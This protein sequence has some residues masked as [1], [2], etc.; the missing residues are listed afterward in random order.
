[1]GR[2]NHQ[3][4]GS[5]S[6][7]ASRAAAASIGLL[8]SDPARTA[9]EAAAYLIAHGCSAEVVLDAEPE[10]PIAFVVTN[11]FAETVLNFRKHVIHMPRP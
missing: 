8:S 5:E 7:A 11:A 3:L 6:Y 1:V 4:P 10:L 9:E 2:D